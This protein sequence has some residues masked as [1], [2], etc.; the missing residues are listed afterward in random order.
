MG[1]SSGFYR[2]NNGKR[3]I[4]YVKTAVSEKL[5][6]VL[7]RYDCVA[8]KVNNILTFEQSTSFVHVKNNSR[9]LSVFCFSNKQVCENTIL[10][11]ASKF[12]YLK[13]EQIVVAVCL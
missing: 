7:L 2:N 13:N 1:H 11:S 5:S 6:D 8:L 3:N 9:F 4:N 12:T 10:P